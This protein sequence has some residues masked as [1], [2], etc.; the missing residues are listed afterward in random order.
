MSGTPSLREED[1][2][3]GMEDGALVLV[4]LPPA[5]GTLTVA[6]AQTIAWHYEFAPAYMTAVWMMALW[7][8]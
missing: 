3:G 8:C 1:S 2:F 7:C 6:V 4:F 5:G